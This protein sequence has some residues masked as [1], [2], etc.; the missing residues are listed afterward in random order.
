MSEQANNH[1][2]TSPAIK[3]AE[4]KQT[5]EAILGSKYFSHAPQKR[6]FLRLICDFYLNDRVRELNEYLLAREVFNRGASYHPGDDPIVRVV[7]HDVRKKLETYYQH[8]GGGDS[9]RLQIPVGSYEPQFTRRQIQSPE[10]DSAPPAAAEAT[11][12]ETASAEATA[13]EMHP[14]KAMA[15]KA[16][17]DKAMATEAT[18][19]A[20]NRLRTLALGGG[21]ILLAIALVFF[22][23]SNRELRRQM[24]AAA[25]QKIQP[26]SNAFWEPFLK[27]NDPTLLVLS[28]PLSCLIVTANDP[29]A[30]VK[31][32]IALNE[33]QTAEITRFAQSVRSTAVSDITPNPRL[34]P[35]LDTFTGVGE[36]V[37]LY[38]VTDLF[39]SAGRS[40]ILKQSRTVSA[41]DLK[42]HDVILLGG[43]LSNDWSGKLPVTEDFVH[44]SGA[45]IENRHPQPGE[46]RIYRSRFNPQN[47]DL[48][49]DF[50]LIT[51]KPNI[52]YENTVVVL[53]G[54]HSAGTEAAAEF[55]TSK[56]YL[57]EF[58]GRLS[59]A[60]G[61]A[62][63]PKY[64][65]AL[66]KVGVENGI[67][68]TISLLTIHELRPSNR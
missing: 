28:N 48:V 16:M 57:H 23:L 67:P 43:F 37:G 44:T 49:E 5:L 4:V 36:A 54:N 21:M 6:K 1:S 32:S 25:E 29:Q 41:E 17:A 15:A 31:R 9:I 50:A 55:V 8:E 58:T 39:R 22:A 24:Q 53:A 59:R 64:Y 19:G 51:V 62:G 60:G 7:A 66:L 61:A 2:T 11:S 14:A 68:T 42:K 46:E 34:I 56:N 33:E 10:P 3:P 13:A 65:Q 47:G 63:T 38:R 40:L 26:L 12:P 45:A 30:Q 18:A 52:L 27:N 35:S 20:T